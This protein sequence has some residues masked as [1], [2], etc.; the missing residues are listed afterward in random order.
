MHGLSSVPASPTWALR[1]LFEF[2]DYT[3]RTAPPGALPPVLWLDRGA[4]KHWHV[5]G[6]TSGLTHRGLVKVKSQWRGCGGW[7]QMKSQW[8]GGKKGLLG[9]TAE[10]LLMHVRFLLTRQNGKLAPVPH[11]DS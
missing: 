10:L 1:C 3:L 6:E 2:F 9:G 8:R 4:T 5:W 7:G 11:A